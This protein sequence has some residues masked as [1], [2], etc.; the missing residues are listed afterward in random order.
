MVNYVYEWMAHKGVYAETWQVLASLGTPF[1]Y[2]FIM[3]APWLS[4]RFLYAYVNED[5]KDRRRKEN[6]RTN[7]LQ[8][9]TR[10]VLFSHPCF[11]SLSRLAKLHRSRHQKARFCFYY[12]D[13]DFRPQFTRSTFTHVPTYPK[14]CGRARAVQ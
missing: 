11:Q 3:C 14:S 5:L 2:A 6:R 10:I 9:S 4:C 13:S 12:V 1:V 7:R 8:I